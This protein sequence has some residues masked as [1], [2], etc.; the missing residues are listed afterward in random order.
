MA[1]AQRYSF[2][3][4][5][6]FSGSS[7]NC[8]KEVVATHLF[9]DIYPFRRNVRYHSV[10]VDA[11]PT[12]TTKVR[13]LPQKCN[14]I[15]P[16]PFSNRLQLHPDTSSPDVID[17]GHVVGHRKFRNSGWPQVL[18]PSRFTVSESTFRP[19]LDAKCLGFT[20]EGSM[21]NV[22]TRLGK[23]T[24]QSTF[25]AGRLRCPALRKMLGYGRSQSPGEAKQATCLP[26]CFRDVGQREMPKKLLRPCHL[27]TYGRQ[28]YKR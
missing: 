18:R 15:R 10:E 27:L 6:R 25:A 26:L 9:L 21:N 2:Q 4:L 20:E 23:F 28:E 22:S 24:R 5:L 8:Q 12:R 13:V 7:R 17:L 14:A 3:L 1:S 11:R 19:W 16:R